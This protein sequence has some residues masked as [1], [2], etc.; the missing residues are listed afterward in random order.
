M[1]KCPL[2]PCPYCGEAK[3]L[4]FYSDDGAYYANVF[5]MTCGLYGPWGKGKTTRKAPAEKWNSLPR[6]GLADWRMER[7]KL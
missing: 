4:R 3:Y 1:S 2:K 6:M 7:R 5:C